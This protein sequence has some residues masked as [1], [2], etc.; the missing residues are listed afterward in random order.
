MQPGRTW[1][2]SRSLW[3]IIQTM[4]IIGIGNLSWWQTAAERAEPSRPTPQAIK[5]TALTLLALPTRPLTT[6]PTLTPT[7]SAA[8]AWP[9]DTSLT[10]FQRHP[11]LI[12][13]LGV[14][15]TGLFFLLL[16]QAMRDPGKGE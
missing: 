14:V 2:S 7:E 11:V 5:Q 12:A 1:W 6:S 8:M 13:G 9:T 4:L 16:T 3:L 15:A 10:P